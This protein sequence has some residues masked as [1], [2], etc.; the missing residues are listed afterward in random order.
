MLWRQE[1]EGNEGSELESK[2]VEIVMRRKNKNRTI[3]LASHD[4]TKLKVIIMPYRSGCSRD[5][6]LYNEG[7]MNEA[8][9]DCE[10]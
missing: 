3:V 4:K 5:V 6:E 7:G 8:S 2:M 1:W 9:N 10:G